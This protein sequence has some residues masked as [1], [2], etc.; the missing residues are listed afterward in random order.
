VLR[1]TVRRRLP[2]RT[3]IGAG[4]RYHHTARRRPLVGPTSWA[5]AARARSTAAPVRRRRA[6]R[7]R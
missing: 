1:K 4:L 7:H 6:G 3:R 5:A 2:W